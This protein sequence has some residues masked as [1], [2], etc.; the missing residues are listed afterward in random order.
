[1]TTV[2]VYEH[3]KDDFNWVIRKDGT[4]VVAH[5]SLENALLDDPKA[6]VDQAGLQRW[7]DHLSKMLKRR[8]RV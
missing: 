8:T 3:D 5:Q 1:M 2:I 7:V 6:A 4:F